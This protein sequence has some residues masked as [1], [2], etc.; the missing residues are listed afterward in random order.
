MAI[1]RKHGLLIAG[2]EYIIY[3]LNTFINLIM[4]KEK[5]CIVSEETE[6]ID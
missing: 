3:I 4:N 2:K 6:L 1:Y 5:Q